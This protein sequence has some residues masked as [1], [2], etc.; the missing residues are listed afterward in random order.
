MTDIGFL[1]VSTAECLTVFESIDK[2]IFGPQLVTV[3]IATQLM[4]P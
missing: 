1:G 4:D 2:E 3:C